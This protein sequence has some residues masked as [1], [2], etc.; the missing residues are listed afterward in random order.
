[1]GRRRAARIWGDDGLLAYGAATG[2]SHMGRRR[3]LA[4]G[5]VMGARMWRRRAH[6]CGSNGCTHVA[7]TGTRM[8]HRRVLAYG[9]D[10]CSHTWSIF[11][12]VVRE[13]K[14]KFPCETSHHEMMGVGG[15]GGW[16]QP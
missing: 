16:K 10:G 1:M 9:S 13:G 8:W 2:C 15:G 6:A 11:T 14:K 12:M 5:A 7:A 3:A 4:Y